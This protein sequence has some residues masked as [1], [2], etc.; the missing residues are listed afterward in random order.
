MSSYRLTLRGKVVL[1]GFVIVLFV[2]C[3]YSLF[4]IVK[5]FDEDLKPSIVTAT[6]PVTATSEITEAISTEHSEDIQT[7][8]IEEIIEDTTESTIEIKNPE[9]S[10]SKEEAIYSVYDLEDLRQFKIVFYFE[11]DQSKVVLDRQ[12]IE[13]ILN[14]TKMYPNEKISITGHVN[15]YPDY[16]NTI[17]GLALSL[18]RAEFIKEEMIELG[19]EKSLLSVYNFG[20]ESPI[21]TD[22]GN[23]YK[24]DRVEVYF[25]DH[26]IIDNGSK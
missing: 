2:I 16:K 19:I 11:K 8:T 5:Y 6:E 26:F 15:G 7:A 3:M 21:F 18:L 12:I 1:T 4:Y 9:E 14:I 23:Q 10:I 17:E 24:N 13:I 22:Y 25:T 20:L